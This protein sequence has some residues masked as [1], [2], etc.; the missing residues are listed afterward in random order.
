[1][2][3]VAVSRMHAVGATK[4]LG[5]SVLQRWDMDSQHVLFVTVDSLRA[6]HVGHHGYDRETTPYLDEL[7]ASGSQFNSAFTH[8]GAT[9]FAFPSLLTSVYPMMYGGYEQVTDDQTMISE[10]FDEHG[11]TT[12]GFHSNLYLSENYG[13]DR[14]WDEFYDSKP[15]SSAATGLRSFV[16]NT[17][18]GTPVYSY[19]S[20]AYNYFESKTGVNVGS[21]LVPADEKTDMALEFLDRRQDDENVF[22]WVHYMDPHHPFLPPERY[23]RMFRDETVGRRES[24]KMRQKLLERPEAVTE[25]ELQQQ[26]D[27]YDAETR[28]WDDNLERLVEG[29]RE[30]L[31]DLTVGVTS[32]HGEHFLEKG[33]FSGAHHYKFK[34]H[35]PLVFAGEDWPDS[36]EY[37]EMVGFVDVPETFIDHVGFESPS[38][39]HG[40]SLKRL[41]EDG[42][43]DREAI[44]GGSEN[45]YGY[46]TS[47]WTYIWHED[48]PDELYD[49]EADP[50]EQHNVLE[51]H[52]ERVERFQAEIDEHRERVAATEQD[53]DV[54]L[55]DEVEDRLRRLGYME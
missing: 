18:R 36:G 6:D 2:R 19:I 16:K 38:N 28:F 53:V 49:L 39:W 14:G 1:M 24:V 40:Q 32:D 29:A 30:K 23:Q 44:I 20:D 13:Y 10:L 27:L 48:E 8:G 12:G 43:W 37:D 33:Y 17:L 54:D 3:E 25:S 46:R 55:E 21:Y 31:G 42:E 26:K 52:P 22:L 35:V 9:R 41:T 4:V 5:D 11:Y 15:D 47:E 50:G 34:Q 7:A 51:E 45:E